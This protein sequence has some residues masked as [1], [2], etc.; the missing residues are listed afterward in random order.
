MFI[1]YSY[2]ARWNYL[3]TW[4]FLIVYLTTKGQIIPTI[5]TNLP[6]KYKTI[7]LDSFDLI[8]HVKV[9]DALQSIFFRDIT[10][11]QYT[12][13]SHTLCHIGKTRLHNTI[14]ELKQF[15]NLVTCF[16]EQISW[17]GYGVSGTPWVEVTADLIRLWQVT[18]GPRV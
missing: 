14:S 16:I 2:S 7:T 4:I 12:L 17:W 13:V 5:T 10:W 9:L 6:P 11:L 1:L 8:C 15:S 18:L 3:P